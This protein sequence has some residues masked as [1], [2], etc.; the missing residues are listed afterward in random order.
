[1]ETPHDLHID[2]MRF[3]RVIE[4][5]RNKDSINEAVKN[6]FR[7]IIKKVEPSSQIRSKYMVVQHKKTGY[8]SW[9]Y[10]WIAIWDIY[11]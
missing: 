2:N 1:M 4:T 8:T 6:G 5:A 7:V 10:I 3:F 11:G 9:T